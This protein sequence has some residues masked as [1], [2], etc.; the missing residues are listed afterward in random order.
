MTR[1]SPTVLA[2]LLLLAG[3]GAAWACPACEVGI[4]DETAKTAL[5]GY[6]WSYGFLAATPL[7]IVST[8]LAGILRAIMADQGG[9]APDVA[10]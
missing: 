6:L 5:S 10:A 3:V 1:P 8:V 4:G 2:V 9:Q 7:V